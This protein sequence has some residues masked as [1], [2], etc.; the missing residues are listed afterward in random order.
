MS[1]PQLNRKLNLRFSIPNQNVIHYNSI[2]THYQVSN[3]PLKVD[4][5]SNCSPIMD[6]GQLGSCSAHALAACDEFLQLLEIRQNLPLGQA[7][8]EYIL[9]NFAPVSR[10]FL[11]WNERAREGTT[12]SDSGVTTLMDGALSLQQYGACREAL[13]IYDES[14]CF[15]QP[16]QAAFTEGAAHKLPT[17]YQLNTLYDMQRC[18]AN[19][20]PFMLGFTV[21]NSFMSAQVAA[22]GVGSMPGPN[23]Q[24]DGGHAVVCVGYDFTDPRNPVFNLRNSWGVSFG[25]QGYFTLPQAYLVGSGLANDFITLRRV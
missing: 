18:L 11:Y 9:N 24:V 12:S 5:R 15:V 23:D 2:E 7:P 13:W 8:Q 25:M 21:Y 20:Y 19:G 17:Y 3:L 4:L 6:Q 22:T 10:L 16:P 14:Q 1:Q